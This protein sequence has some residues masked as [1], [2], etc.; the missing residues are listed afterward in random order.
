MNDPKVV[1]GQ[2]MIASIKVSG[3]FYPVFCAKSCSFE[4]T[5]EIIN[6]TSVNDGLFTKRRVRRTEWSGSASGVLVTNN[7]GDRF[8]PFYLLQDSV[9][10][11]SRTWQFE[12][13]NL[14]GDI[15]TIEGDALIQNLPISG[16][17]QSFVQ[18]TVNIIGTGAFAI[19]V[20]SS[21]I[22]SDENV[23]SDYWNTTAGANSISGLSVDGKSL[24]GKTILAISRE[25]TVYD[26]I[27]SG[28]PT[29]RIALFNSATGT[30]TFDSN[31][32]FN[33]SET[34]WA[35]WKD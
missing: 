7:D 26:P 6:K 20:S 34:V 4:M 10:R 11:S 17:V 12:F 15:K 5:N 32:P 25:G 30:I 28:S 31:I 29:N 22:V 16:D 19:D 27:T 13:T 8:S 2:N 3:T 1:R 9:R 33:P 35:M 18:C 23:D 24:Q 21:S 14:D